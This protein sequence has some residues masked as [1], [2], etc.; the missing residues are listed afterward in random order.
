MADN[1]ILS[2]ST[3]ADMQIWAAGIMSRAPDFIIGDSYLLRWFV[4]PRN[5]FSNV[6]LHEIRQSDD[7]RAM[8]DHPWDNRSIVLDGEYIEHTPDGSFRR[9]AGDVIDRPATALH[10]LEI[11]DG[12]PVKTMF[13][14]GPKIREWGF[15]C[16][17]GWVHWEDFCLPGDSS[18]VGAGCGE[19]A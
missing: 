6:Y 17:K 7:D 8:H 12:R 14:T 4:I 18:K 15:A 5:S 13:I 10:R 16:P 11:L 19:F 1:S 2:Y 3:L 9:V